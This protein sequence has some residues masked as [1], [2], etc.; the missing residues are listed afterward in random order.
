MIPMKTY[1]LLPFAF[2][3]MIIV[4][5]NSC[6]KTDTVT[7]IKDSTVVDSIRDTVGLGHIRFISMIPGSDIEIDNADSTTE[8][9][10]ASNTISGSY[11][12]VPPEASMNLFA[13]IPTLVGLQPMPLPAPGPTFNTY[14]LFL[15]N[16]QTT[17]F[18]FTRSIDSEKF[19][20]PPPDSC[21]F[22]LINGDPNS[23]PFFVDIDTEGH[24]I[25]YNNSNPQSISFTT[26]SYYAR[27]PA[28]EH[29]FYLRVDNPNDP[30][31]VIS[32]TYS[33]LCEGGQYYTA[34]ASPSG[35]ISIQQ[36]E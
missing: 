12:P 23:D 28:G 29:T 36:E 27:I 31:K 17:T 30:Q 14:A 21:Y 34:Q 1:H 13:F 8:F 22:R 4:S 5:M 18:Q 24:S 19:T 2:G 16:G 7:Q 32:S 11:F 25:F 33:F 26:F 6:T 20:P 9:T 15:I 3:V 35:T 10:Y